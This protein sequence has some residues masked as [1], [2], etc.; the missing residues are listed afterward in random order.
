MVISDDQGGTLTQ[1][2]SVTLNGSG[3]PD[4]TLDGDI[5]GTVT[6][7]D[8]I[9]NGTSGTLTV[10]D[11]DTGQ[12]HFEAVDESALVAEFGDFE[13]DESTSHWTYTLDQGR[14]NS[15]AG[16]YVEH[17]VLT[18]V[19]ADSGD[20]PVGTSVSET[21]Y[22]RPGG[23]VLTGGGGDD[24]FVFAAGAGHNTIADF[25]PGD[26]IDLLDHHPFDSNSAESFEAWNTDSETVEQQNDNTLI[27]FDA[28]DT[29][30]LLD[31]VSTPN[32]FILHP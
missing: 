12:G 4:A 16:T 29:I 9:P 32:D 31:I 14:A 23:D 25:T 1:T 18:V 26:T 17:D 11:L 8:P 20:L 2:V 6:E 30:L 28:N 3:S 27:L 21:F 24:N 19:A 13:F 15:L 5:A 7:D 10:H 22:S